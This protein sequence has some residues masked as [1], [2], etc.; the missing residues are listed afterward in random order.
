MLLQEVKDYRDIF[1]NKEIRDVIGYAMF[2]PTRGRIQNVA[3]SMYAKQQGR[4]YVAVEGDRI[5]GIVGFK[6]IDNIKLQVMHI[7]VEEDMRGQG[8]GRKMLEEAALL[9]RVNEIVVETDD[10]ALAFYKRCGFKTKRMP[11]QGYGIDRYLC[12]LKLDRDK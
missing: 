3:Q 8:I 2:N 11:D 4:F 6:K 1:E 9:E 5:I 12:T 7:A 10:D